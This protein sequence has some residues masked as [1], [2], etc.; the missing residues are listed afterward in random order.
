MICIKNFKKD[1]ISVVHVEPQ[2][3]SKKLH[4]VWISASVCVGRSAKLMR[5]S[6]QHM[7]D[8]V[9]VLEVSQWSRFKSLDTSFA[10]IKTILRIL[11]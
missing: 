1:I 2:T 8:I 7:K 5:E 4:L 6:E 9:K 3:T 10:D 11:P